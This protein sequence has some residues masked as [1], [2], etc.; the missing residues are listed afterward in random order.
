[1]KWGAFTWAVIL[2]AA[3]AGWI[4]SG[5]GLIA[6]PHKP[7]AFTSVIGGQEAKVIHN[8]RV[9]SSRA[10]NYQ[11]S[12]RVQG[13]T[14]P[15]RTVTV[16]SEVE[17]RVAQLET[18]KG[19]TVDA[20]QLLARISLNGADVRLR[21]VEALVKQRHLEHKAAS[22][23]HGQGYRS[24]TQL[25]EAFAKLEAARAERYR[26]RKAV[27]DTRLTAPFA[28]VVTNR[29][30]ELGDYI[31]KGDAVAALADLSKIVVSGT[32]A[33]GERAHVKV[34][35]MATARFING[36]EREGIVRFIATVADAA[37]RT[38]VIEVE[39]PNEHGDLY[40]GQ[41]VELK[42]NLNE[43]IA[44]QIP[45]SLLSLNTEGHL[46]VKHLDAADKVL[47]QPVEIVAQTANG[48]WVRGLPEQA[49]VIVVGQD[50]VSAG[51]QVNAE[52]AGFLRT[53]ASS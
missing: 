36:S 47:F 19:D 27:A 35:H 30:I 4:F 17:G 39:L 18:A 28:G 24:Q 3:A 38:Y 1:V 32:I 43:V 11:S 48:I 5:E 9:A 6:R 31:K 37:T 53:S 12:L 33:E 22:K 34:G 20:Q 49:R 52:Q 13:T 7:V 16:R 23:L 15:I 2:L 45:A 8:V 50:G 42:L 21:E 29:P 25:A 41:T 14:R 40:D 51:D 46:G 10:Q 26:A 44:H